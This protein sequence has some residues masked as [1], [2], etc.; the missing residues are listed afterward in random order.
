MCGHRGRAGTR[1]KS[2]HN[3]SCKKGVSSGCATLWRLSARRSSAGFRGLDID[4]GG[5]GADFAQSAPSRKCVYTRKI[6]PIPGRQPAGRFKAQ[7]SPGGVLRLGFKPK[8]H[9]GHQARVRRAGKT[10]GIQIP[11]LGRIWL[12]L[13]AGSSL[14]GFNFSPA[15]RKAFVSDAP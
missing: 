6:T 4:V 10:T 7:K 14:R 13:H 5:S 2:T 1:A 9:F 15:Q 8:R 11:G 3:L 12:G